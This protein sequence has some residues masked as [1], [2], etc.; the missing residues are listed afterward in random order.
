MM[1]KHK[2]CINVTNS[3]GRKQTVLKSGVIKLP[4]RLLRFLLG[5][6]SE[7]LVLSHGQSVE[8]V[9]IHEV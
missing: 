3:C 1:L 8:G 7:I 2:V 4:Q 9:E 6:F 5:D